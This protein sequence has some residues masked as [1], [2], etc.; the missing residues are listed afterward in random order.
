LDK[1]Y[2]I[3][4][5]I[6]KVDLLTRRVQQL[7]V[8]EKENK[9]L[10][11]ENTALKHRLSKYEHPKNSNNSSIPHPKMKTAPGTTKVCV[12]K[13]GSGPGGKKGEKAIR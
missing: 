10:R 7:E 2:T 6:Q 13:Q 8:L 3:L 9:K 4:E 11:K 12:K 1:D 5:L